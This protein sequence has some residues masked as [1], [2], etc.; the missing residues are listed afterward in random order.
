MNR[1]ALVALVLG[2]CWLA[3]AVPVAAQ[4]ATTD[5]PL[6]P[7]DMAFVESSVGGFLE[8]AFLLQTC[9]DRLRERRAE[10]AKDFARAVAAD[11]SRLTGRAVP[12]RI[13]IVDG[14]TCN[15]RDGFERRMREIWR[16]LRRA[17]EIVVAL[18]ADASTPPSTR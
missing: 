3:L 18:D 14:S 1:L 10:E 8:T 9:G 11:Y 15:S 6:P 4:D 12:H 17:R 5:G 16:D 13:L 7:T 2:G